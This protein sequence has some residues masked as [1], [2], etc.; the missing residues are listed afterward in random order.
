MGYTWQ[1]DTSI[2]RFFH[3]TTTTRRDEPRITDRGDVL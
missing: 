3:T 1:S 2:F